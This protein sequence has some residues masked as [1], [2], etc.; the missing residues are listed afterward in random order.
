MIQ[1]DIFKGTFM[2]HL[3]TRFSPLMVG[4]L[5]INRCLSHCFSKVMMISLML[6]KGSECN[7]PKYQKSLVPVLTG[8]YDEVKLSLWP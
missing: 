2:I 8:P 5:V 6:E 7:S 4:V 3:S 1:V